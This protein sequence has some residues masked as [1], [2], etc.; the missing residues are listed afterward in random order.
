MTAGRR[1]RLAAVIVAAF[2]AVA[3]LSSPTR[4]AASST[5]YDAA[6]AV[7]ERFIEHEMADKEL[8]A[9]SIALVDDQRTV[10]ARGFGFADPERRV[11][12]SADTV[13][14]VGSVSKLFTDIALMQLVERGEVDLDAEVARYLPDFRPRNPFGRPITLRHLMSHRSGLVREPPVGSYFDPTEPSLAATIES[15]DRTSLVYPPGT[16]TKYSN[17][18]L[19]AIGY[20]VERVNGEPFARS[21][22]RTVLDPLGMR[23]SSFEATPEVRANLAKAYMWT[24]DGRVFPA[25]TFA[26]GID[27]AGALYTTVN[28]LA[29]FWSALFA[30][31]RGAIGDILQPSTLDSMLAPQ[32]AEPGAKRAF[33]LGFSVGELDGRPTA[34]HGGAVYGFATTLRGLPREK[35]G[36]VVVTTKDA[37]NAVTGRVA[38]AALRA[39]LAV[40]EGKPIPQPEL[41]SPVDR[42]RARELAGRYRKG[43][44]GYEFVASADR[45]SVLPFEGGMPARVRSVGDEL[46]TDD[47]LAYG[48]R[49]LPRDGAITIDGETFERVR[50]RKPRAAPERWRGLIGE[51]GWDHDILYVLERDG[52]LWALIEWFEFDPLEEVSENVFAFPDRGL[53]DGERLVFERD[54]S[55]VAIRVEAAGVV[56]ERRRV[57]PEEG[58]AQLR[59]EPVRPVAELLEEARSAQPP[60]ETGEF[61]LTGSG[62]AHRARLDHRARRPLRHHRQLPGLGLLPGA[63]RFPAATGGRGAGPRASQAEEAGLWGPGAR[64][65]PAVAGDQGLLGS[66]ARRQED[67]RRRSRAGIPPQPR[68]RRR[69]QS[70]R[71]ADRQ[72]G[73]DGGHLRRG[74]RPFEPGLPGRHLAPALAPRPA[75][76]GDGVGRVHRLRERVVALRLPGLAPLPHRQ[77]AVSA[78]GG[79]GT[80]GLIRSRNR[81]A[82]AAARRGALPCPIPRRA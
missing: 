2:S 15:L 63:S 30:G 64:W 60:V 11:E 71:P 57:G 51:Y 39:M 34:G 21:V 12:A 25:P 58:A 73:R 76:R 46:V 17:A 28:D 54:A 6:I 80:V 79:V 78:S 9:L 43:R 59:I 37:A 8:P 1:P 32:F 24:L 27:P 14:R 48:L 82:A 23:Q 72:A 4:V 13:Y 74:H 18:A 36:V 52:K 7:L 29:R 31:G 41:T 10:W 44:R 56:F 65:L 16:R 33:G 5:D 22:K 55:G 42:Q 53:Y 35:L 47:R 68:R 26:M 20:V 38:D 45:L 50:T 61:R 3:T 66:D 19:A 77:P 81:V 49:I 70:L 75:A 69:P 40:R 62:G 67:V